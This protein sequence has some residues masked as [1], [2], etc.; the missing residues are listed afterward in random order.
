MNALDPKD[1]WKQSVN[2]QSSQHIKPNISD[3][4]YERNENNGDHISI[5]N[6][7]YSIVLVN[8]ASRD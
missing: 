2:V 6:S 8:V 1:L 5:S 4:K 3:Y 7:N